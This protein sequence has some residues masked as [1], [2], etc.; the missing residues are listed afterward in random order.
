AATKLGLSQFCSFSATSINLGRF[1]IMFRKKPLSAAVH[2]AVTTVAMAATAAAPVIGQAQES[3][4]EVVVT[5]SRIT[6]DANLVTSSPVTQVKAEEL[7]FRGITRVEDLMN[8]LPQIVPELTANEANG[9][10]GTATL[11]LRGLGSDRTL[12][13][14]NGH[15]MGF[16][17]P[18][19]LAPDINQVPG[20]LIERIEVLTGGASSTYGSDAV[21]GVVNFIMKDDFEGIQVDYQYSGY[22]HSQHADAVQDALEAFG[23]EPPSGSDWG[24]GTHDIDLTVG[25][26]TADGRGNIT[27]YVGYR[28]I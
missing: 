7:A 10:T 20:A 17:D 23:E 4:E 27:A 26:N 25:V 22:Q 6:T 3:I 13:L 18:F 28:N 11:D 19:A 5:G 12:V 2:R 16:G 9:A 1:E 8:D 21:S 14:T 24:G 15:R